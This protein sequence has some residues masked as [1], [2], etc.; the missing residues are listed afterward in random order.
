VIAIP[1]RVFQSMKQKISPI[2]R[3]GVFFLFYCFFGAG[4]CH[5]QAPLRSS[6]A[7]AET[8]T[9]P[10]IGLAASVWDV[11][12]PSVCRA[13]SVVI[14]AG[15]E[16]VALLGHSSVDYGAVGFV[17]AS[18]PILLNFKDWTTSTRL[19]EN[20]RSV[21]W[22]EDGRFLVNAVAASRP[23]F[24]HT[25][26]PSR[27]VDQPPA[28]AVYLGG[29]I[30]GRIRELPFNAVVT[31]AAGSSRPRGAEPRRPPHLA[32]VSIVAQP[33]GT[34][35]ASLE[36]FFASVASDEVFAPRPNFTGLVLRAL[37]GEDRF[38]IGSVD[39]SDLRASRNG[40]AS[41]SVDPLISPLNFSNLSV[42]KTGRDKFG[43]FGPG[44]VLPDLREPIGDPLRWPMYAK[45]VADPSTGVALMVHGTDT[46]IAL[47]RST[48]AVVAQLNEAAAL[49]KQQGWFLSGLAHDPASQRSIM[50]FRTLAFTAKGKTSPAMF[51]LLDGRNEKPRFLECTI[52]PA[53]P[54]RQPVRGRAPVGSVLNDPGLGLRMDGVL[55]ELNGPPSAGER[56]STFTETRAGNHRLGVWSVEP[57]S[58]KGT[59]VLFRGGPSVRLIDWGI[60]ELEQRLLDAGWRIV[61]PEYSGAL[62]T[63]PD[64]ARRLGTDREGS[65]ERDASVLREHLRARFGEQLEN[66]PLVI[67]GSS[68]GGPVSTYFAQAMQSEVDGLQL[69]VPFGQWR[70]FVAGGAVGRTGP[71]GELPQD[72]SDRVVFGAPVDAKGR[73]VNDWLNERR[74]IACAMPRVRV[75][76]GDKD[77]RIPPEDWTGPCA[78]HEV[79]VAR[80]F[81]HN[82]GDESVSLNATFTWIEAIANGR[83]A[84]AAPN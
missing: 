29:E 4:A 25:L 45:T 83:P 82:A 12:D 26:P 34:T 15:G 17:R 1:I 63:A 41:I 46:V 69:L 31:T 6:A 47:D 56:A 20:A 37:V 52:Q 59:I 22:L 11:G 19:I 78:R 36:P 51:A 55:K 8:N 3:S 65:L 10:S 54:E 73:H 24:I 30:L 72:V 76:V 77:E 60:S 66:E 75:V 80:G 79:Y 5:P 81:A 44:L 50:V 23:G 61:M 33:R 71:N 9:S 67:I 27:G 48:R 38:D 53:P 57:K 49:A 18:A 13:R 64:V 7:V 21:Q 35:A 40:A 14:S 62:D 16:H 74:A 70:R 32:Y 84:Q 2:S 42:L 58:R 68:F 43:L 28:L 39:G